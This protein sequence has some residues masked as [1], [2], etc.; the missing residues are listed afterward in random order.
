LLASRIFWG[1]P[2]PADTMVA[3]S[4][5]HGVGALLYAVANRVFVIDDFYGNLWS[6]FGSRPFHLVQLAFYLTVSVVVIAL[7][8]RRDAALPSV[9]A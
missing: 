5:T 1:I 9:P 4:D 7:M 8:R 6:N 2:D 3:L